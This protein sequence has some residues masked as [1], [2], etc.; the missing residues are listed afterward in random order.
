MR[1]GPGGPG[2]GSLGMV[3]VLLVQVWGEYV[4]L[5]RLW[6]FC[7]VSARLLPL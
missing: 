2:M 6:L 7:C 3:L 1:G 5:P 4:S